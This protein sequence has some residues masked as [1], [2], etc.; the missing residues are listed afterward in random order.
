MRTYRG[1]LSILEHAKVMLP[2]LSQSRRKKSCCEKKARALAFSFVLQ[3]P[4]SAQ[5]VAE[6]VWHEMQGMCG[7]VDGWMGGWVREWGGGWVRDHIYIHIL[8]KS[9]RN[10]ASQQGKRRW[11]K[12]IPPKKKQLRKRTSGSTLL[13]HGIMQNVANVS[14]YRMYREDYPHT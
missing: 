10:K 8:N 2:I 1:P 3:T 11:R 12:H 6:R 13:S 7:W 5:R 14:I 4:R 9:V